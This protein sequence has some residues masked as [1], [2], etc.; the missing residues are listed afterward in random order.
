MKG[1]RP[2]GMGGGRR[3]SAPMKKGRHLAPNLNTYYHK[4][5]LQNTKTPKQ[6]KNIYQ[7]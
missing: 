4:R 5:R 3:P 1:G 2:G 7:M 6:N